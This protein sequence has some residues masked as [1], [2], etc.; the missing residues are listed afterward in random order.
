MRGQPDPKRALRASHQDAAE[1]HVVMHPCAQQLTDAL[2][3]NSM[4][5]GSLKQCFALWGNIPTIRALMAA[6][7]LV[8]QIRL[9]IWEMLCKCS[10]VNGLE[11]QLAPKTKRSEFD[12]EMKIRLKIQNDDDILQDYSKSSSVMLTFESPHKSALMTPVGRV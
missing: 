5:F 12:F 9:K 7:I 1:P 10:V 4:A 11:N 8:I 6:C 2:E 3:S